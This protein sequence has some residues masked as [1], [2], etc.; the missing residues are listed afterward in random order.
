MNAPNQQPADSVEER[1]RQCEAELEAT[2]AQLE[3]AFK[4]ITKMAMYLT[5]ARDALSE[6]DSPPQI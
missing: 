4:S 1:L 5:E 6:R 2:Q 3:A